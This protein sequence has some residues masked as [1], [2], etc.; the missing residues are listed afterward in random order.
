MSMRAK[1]IVGGIAA[2]FVAGIL[3][4]Y[5]ALIIGNPVSIIVI[6]R[7]IPPYYP[8]VTTSLGHSCKAPCEFDLFT[9]EDFTL[10]MT[11]PGYQDR[12]L[13]MKVPRYANGA[14]SAFPH[15]PDP[16]IVQMWRPPGWKP[17][18]TE[19]Y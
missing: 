16:S 12:V 8:T 17:T 11:A 14:L 18:P 2:M 7:K 19:Q 6:N 1:W 4:L 5:A 3:V 9:D 13:T 10:T 15:Q